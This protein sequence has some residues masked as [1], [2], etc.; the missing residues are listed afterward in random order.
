MSAINHQ[1]LSLTAH[2]TCEEIT[3]NPEGRS[4]EHIQ[5][6]PLRD[7]RVEKSNSQSGKILGGAIG[8]KEERM[9]EYWH[10]LIAEDNIILKT[11]AQER[12]VEIIKDTE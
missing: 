9:V 10:F 5:I 7:K 6:E 1:W 8:E 2:Q 11:G 4:E 3:S 12:R